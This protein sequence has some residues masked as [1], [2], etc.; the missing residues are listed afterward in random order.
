MYKRSPSGEAFFPDA[1]NEEPPPPRSLRHTLLIFIAVFALLQWGWSVARDS[2]LER[3]VVHQ[4]T[5]VPAAALVR[6]LTPAIPAQAV[7]ASIKAPGGGLN[8]LNGC[9][10]T[11]VMFL[12]AAALAAVR[13]SWRYRL[14]AL[15]LGVALIFVLNQARILTLFY[16]YRADRGLFD[17]L[18]TA[19]LP[20][21]LVAATA[22]YFHAVL[23]YSRRRLA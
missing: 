14:P 15:L 6:L 3:L 10:G 20:V 18:H 17:A 19:V 12:L 13:L 1:A 4:A 21:L 11:E 8:I 22:A 7:A 2:W 16:T 5:V 23:H 9:E